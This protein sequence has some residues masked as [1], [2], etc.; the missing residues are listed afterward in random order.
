ME[1]GRG[2]CIEKALIILTSYL[3]AE[4]NRCSIRVGEMLGLLT[5]WENE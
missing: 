1:L 5:E 2:R 4:A 3:V